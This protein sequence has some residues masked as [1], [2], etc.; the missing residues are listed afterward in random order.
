MTKSKQLQK[1]Q[2]FVQLLWLFAHN[3][4]AKSYGGILHGFIVSAV[5]KII[6]INYWSNLSNCDPKLRLV[7]LMYDDLHSLPRD[8]D[9][10]ATITIGTERFEVEATDL[11]SIEI[12]GRGAYGVVERMRHRPSD[13]VM[14][15]KVD[16]LSV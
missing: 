16:Q 8:I 14:A 10:R 4:I 1:L 12:M 3:H 7:V 11:E 2:N 15:V 13:T 9:S 6:C 5:G